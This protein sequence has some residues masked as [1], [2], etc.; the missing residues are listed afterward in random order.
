LIA[1]FVKEVPSFLPTANGE[2]FFLKIYSMN[3]LTKAGGAF[4]PGLYLNH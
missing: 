3:G 1:F 4:W 2:I